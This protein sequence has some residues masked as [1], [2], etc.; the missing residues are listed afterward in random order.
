M[1]ILQAV[2]PGMAAALFLWGAAV[3]VRRLFWPD[4]EGPAPSPA[5]KGEYVRVLAACLCAGLC[6][7]TLFSVCALRQYPGQGLAAAVQRF[8]G[9]NIDSNS[10]VGLAQYGYGTG[11]S[12]L[13]PE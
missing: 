3:C 1:D 6:F 12:E 5:C 7:I 2:L 4:P 13:W 11:S 10:Y 9:Q 8:F